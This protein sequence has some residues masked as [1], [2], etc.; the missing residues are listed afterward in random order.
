MDT[1]SRFGLLFSFIASV[2]IVTGAAVLH[3]TILPDQPALAFVLSLASA[4]VA[5]IILA[6]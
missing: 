2:I 3:S 1:S 6:R 4:T 5:T